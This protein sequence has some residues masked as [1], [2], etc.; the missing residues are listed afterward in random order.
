MTASRACFGGVAVRVNLT[1]VESEWSLFLMEKLQLRFCC[2]F[3]VK[4]SVF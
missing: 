2:K 1:A 3:V 4:F